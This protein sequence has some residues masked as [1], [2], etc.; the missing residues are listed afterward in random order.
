MEIFPAI[1][2]D[3]LDTYKS[4]IK[5][6]ESFSDEVDIDVI[7]DSIFPGKTLELEEMLA[8]ET[9]LVRHIH[10]MVKEPKEQIETALR[11]GARS[12]IVHG[13]ANL[14]WV[15]FDEIPIQMG[16][17]IAPETP[18]SDIEVHLPTLSLVQI[19]TVVPGKQGG[20]L[21]KEQ[22]K[23]VGML[24][25]LSFSGTIKADGGIS[26]A[27]ISDIEEAGFDSV[28]VGSAIWK[29]DN[30]KETYQTLQ[31]IVQNN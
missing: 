2:T 9:S 4:Q 24:R 28:S 7:D 1:L 15:N 16:V 8:I 5:Q 20:D 29:S 23:K 13:K 3:N 10:L 22:Y 26:E 12:I 11:Y 25:A 6:T 30:P 18:I 27:T 31:R 21:L 17:S 14:E 19:M